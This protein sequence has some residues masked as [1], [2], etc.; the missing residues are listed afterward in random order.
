MDAATYLRYQKSLPALSAE[1]LKELGEVVKTSPWFT[2]A[3][4][5]LALNFFRE[6]HPQYGAQLKR[7]A[8]YAPDRRILKSLINQVR[9]EMIPE[10][11]T[12]KVVEAVAEKQEEVPEE[13]KEVVPAEVPLHTATDRDLREQL[14]AIVHKRLAEIEKE[15]SQRPAMTVSRQTETPEAPRILTKEQLIEKFIREEPR[16]TTPKAAFFNPTQTA[17]KSNVDDEEI[18]SETLARLYA[19][20][21][22]IAKAVKIYEKLSL[23]IPEKS[24]YFAAQIEKINL[25]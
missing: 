2:D 7:A 16:I 11:E 18:V 23:L 14:L 24:R 1:S 4:V 12:P 21:G 17:I 19:E 15:R 13:V 25:K 3:Q 20:Q 22:N 5:L 6:D 9:R 8:I 10:P